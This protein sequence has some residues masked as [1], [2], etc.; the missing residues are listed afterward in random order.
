MMLLG[1]TSE[2]GGSVG[3]KADRVHSDTAPWNA[4][5]G[6]GARNVPARSGLGRGYVFSVAQ[7]FLSAVSQGFQ[8]ACESVL[9]KV[10]RQEC[11][12]HGRQECLRYKRS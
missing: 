1:Y 4:D 12:R 10:C 7:T 2:Y 11:R 9:V 8:P 3:Y 6:A 5:S